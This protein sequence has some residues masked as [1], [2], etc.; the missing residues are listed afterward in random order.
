MTSRAKNGCCYALLLVAG[1]AEAL[2]FLCFCV[3]ELL[4]PRGQSVRL[5]V[6]NPKTSEAKALFQSFRLLSAK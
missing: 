4:R 2:H 3:A 6:E 1:L 5:G